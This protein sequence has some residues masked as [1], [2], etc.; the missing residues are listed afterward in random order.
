MDPI[1]TEQKT[2]AIVDA[3]RR[4]HG[5]ALREGDSEFLRQ[6]LTRAGLMLAALDRVPLTNS[7]EPDLIFQI[8]DQGH[9]AGP[10]RS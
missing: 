3:V 2:E 4:K 5:D 7:D 8:E 1:A 6:R 10:S 9:S